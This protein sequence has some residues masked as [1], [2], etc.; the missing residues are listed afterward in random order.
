MSSPMRV[1]ETR[2]M[3]DG[4][5][6]GYTVHQDWKPAFHIG[7]TRSRLHL[8]PNKH[9]LQPKFH[10]RPVRLPDYSVNNT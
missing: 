8:T 5:S 4:M 10:Q 9:P 7:D 6:A 2:V 3:V 1:P